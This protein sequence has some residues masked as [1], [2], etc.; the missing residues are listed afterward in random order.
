MKRAPARWLLA[1][2]ALAAA[3]LVPWRR[4]FG[5]LQRPFAAAGT[6]VDARAFGLFDPATASPA[7]VAQLEAQLAAAAVDHASDQALKQENDDLRSR[8]NFVARAK[9][10][11]VSADV[12]ARTVGADAD[13]FEI[14][15][16][17][18]DGLAV[19]MPAVVEDGVLAGKVVSVSDA[20]A[21]VAAVTDPGVRTAVSLLNGARTI[22]VATGLDG[23]M[24]ALTYIPKDV[25]VEANEIVVTS[26]LEDR[27]PSGLVIGVVNA[28]ESAGTDPF[29]QAVIQPLA[30]PRRVSSVS[31]IVGSA[32]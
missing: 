29:K 3:L 26:G 14:D 22:G 18:R 8:L 28:V 32:P 30:D 16:G 23:T 4:L 1:A 21:V 19:G 24:M 27:V 20:D 9:A 10:R 6:W 17:S 5:A 7:R 2:L 15:R 12:V 25:D 11:M 13:R 31:I